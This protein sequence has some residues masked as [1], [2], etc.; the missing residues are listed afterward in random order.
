[1]VTD[2]TPAFPAA[3]PGGTVTL[4]ASFIGT[5]PIAYQ[6]Q[7]DKGS[8]LTNIPGATASTLVLTDIQ[9]SDAGGYALYASNVVGTASSDAALL[10]VYP[11]PSHPFTVNFQWHSTEGGDAGNYTGPGIPGFGTGTY[12]NQVVG[13]TTFTPG[14]FSSQ[15]AVADDGT[16]AIGITWTLTTGGSWGWGLVPANSIPLLDSGASAYGTQPFSL[17][18]PNGFYRVVAF[19]CNGS[20]SSTADAG[21]IITMNGMSQTAL[22]TQNT[23]FVQG[24]NYV[25]FSNIWVSTASLNGTWGPVTGKSYGSLNGFQLDFVGTVNETPTNVT[26]SVSGNKLT[27]SWPA[28]HIGW[29]VLAQT[30]HLTAGVSLN[31]ADWGRVPGSQNTNQLQITIDPAHPAG[32]Y[33][34][35]YP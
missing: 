24:N 1:M 34:M 17:I 3:F 13:P 5:L 31:P 33:Q 10:T 35:V 27:L 32:Y 7:V 8:G 11:Q 28:D 29:S 15:P 16:T 25:I 21:A 6:W 9:P 20:E 2:T 30:N 14:T 19:S 12:W 26:A 22:P 23:S 18:L 4:Q